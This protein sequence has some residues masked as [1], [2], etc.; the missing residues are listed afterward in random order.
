[1]SEIKEC[2]C[3]QNNWAWQTDG[4]ARSWIRCQDCG[5]SMFGPDIGV[6]LINWDVTDIP[7]WILKDV[8]IANQSD[9]V[10]QESSK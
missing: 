6:I 4:L 5:G 2:T 10:V 3:G 9:G 1:M 8:L 7:D